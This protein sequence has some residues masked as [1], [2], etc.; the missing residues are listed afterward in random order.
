MFHSLPFRNSNF[1]MQPLF[2]WLQ[3]HAMAIYPWRIGILSK[4]LIGTFSWQKLYF[5]LFNFLKNILSIQ[6]YSAEAEICFMIFIHNKLRITLCMQIILSHNKRSERIHG[7]MIIK[8]SFIT[9]M[10]IVWF[11]R[12]CGQTYVSFHSK[13]SFCALPYQDMVLH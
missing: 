5:Y 10:S 13:I 8:T 2:T 11:I 3:W 4:W 6:Q 7:L 9:L 12:K 1:N